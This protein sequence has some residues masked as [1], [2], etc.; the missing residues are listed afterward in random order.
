MLCRYQR[1]STTSRGAFWLGAVEHRPQHRLDRTK[2]SSTRFPAAFPAADQNTAHTQ[3]RFIAVNSVSA[4]R[5]DVHPPY[6]TAH[7]RLFWTAAVK[8]GAYAVLD[9]HPP[10]STTVFPVFRRCAVKHDKTGRFPA[11]R[12]LARPWQGND[13]RQPSSVTYGCTL[14]LCIIE[15][16]A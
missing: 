15:H 2:L 10:S 8:P 13:S 3:H 7:R 4:A 5:I 11:P 14:R 1:S 6:W 16:W 12:R 9:G